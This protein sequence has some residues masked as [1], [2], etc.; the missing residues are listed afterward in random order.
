MWKTEQPRNLPSA[1]QASWSWLRSWNNSGIENRRHQNEE[2]S[3]RG[4]REEAGC[5]RQFSQGAIWTSHNRRE[6]CTTFRIMSQIC[7]Q[8][9]PLSVNHRPPSILLWP[10]FLKEAN[11][12]LRRKCSKGVQRGLCHKTHI[13]RRK[14][15]QTK[16][17]INL[18]LGP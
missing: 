4:K 12:Q 10:R 11:R 9:L 8:K 16:S 6:S 18:P 1:N 14:T 5:V 17:H 2:N 7:V 15:K 13:W 3:P